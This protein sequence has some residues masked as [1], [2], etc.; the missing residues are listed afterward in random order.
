MIM[1]YRKLSGSGDYVFGLGPG[2]FY[3]D[4][5]EAVAQAV[6]TR[7]KLFQG[8]WFLDLTRGTPYESQILGTGKA[9][10]YDSAIQAVILETPGVTGLASYSSGVDQV[11]RALYINCTIDTLYGTTPLVTTL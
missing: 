2:N 9:T 4:S 5:P 1:I 10:L 11:T 8:E 7:L 6:L 3:K